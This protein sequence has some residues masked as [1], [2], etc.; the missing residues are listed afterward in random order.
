MTSD[1]TTA[2]QAE[3][4][5]RNQRVGILARH[6]DKQYSF[7][8]DGLYLV[9]TGSIPIS[10]TL[11]LVK[12]EFT[13]THLHP[14][15]D[16]LIMEGWLLN[17][18]EKK[19]H[20]DKKNRWE[21]LMQVGSNPIGA[22]SV[23]ALGNH[24][25]VSLE[26]VEDAD[27][28]TKLYPVTVV[29][30][31]G[32]CS[33]CLRTVN[34]QRTYH[35]ACYK[36]LWGTSKNLFAKLNELRPLQSFSQTVDY[37]SISGAQR[38]GLFSLER[39]ELLL[40]S[41]NSMYVL[42]PEGDYP[43]LPANEHL[44]MT[45]ARQLGFD[46]PPTGLIHIEEVGLVF[47]IKRFDRT[48]PN[49][50]LLIEDMAQIYE[51]ASDNKYSLSH[52]KIAEAIR[53]YTQ[54]GPLNLNDFFRRILFCYLTANGDMHLKNWSLLEM[55]KNPGL[56]RLSPVYDWLNTRIALPSEKNDLAI[57]LRGKQRKMQRSYFEK[58]ALEDLKLNSNY[59]EKVFA[60]ISGWEH[61]LRN[62]I[63][64]SFLSGKM[65]KI[66]LEILKERFA[67]LSKKNGY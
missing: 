61:V 44:T 24:G 35:S 15:F 22:V 50:K 25:Q 51:E 39:N 13:S 12:K 36:A 47:V 1:K 9:Q 66:Y 40:N 58:F 3:V 48:I 17:Q 65:K 8:Y 19:F 28:K 42:K 4:R 5:L 7:V 10:V 30:H 49:R 46:I 16:N 23:H 14:F 43:E 62:L 60:E 67:V 27:V 38:K 52:E 33:F 2:E 45:A 6:S 56:Y 21:L 11:P 53:E 54:A 55:E 57:P 64:K 18:A 26:I 20:I 34:S 31:E 29:A 59:V 32:L 63:P 41:G 37:G